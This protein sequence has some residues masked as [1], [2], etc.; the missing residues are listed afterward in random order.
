[1]NK[2][3]IITTITA[4]NAAADAMAALKQGASGTDESGWT[5]KPLQD[6][7]PSLK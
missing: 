1:M 7:Y 3:P 5:V 6:Y 4:A 2:I